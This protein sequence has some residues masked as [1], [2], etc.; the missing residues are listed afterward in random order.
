[1]R[2]S[3]RG[4]VASVVG[5]FGFAHQLL[6]SCKSLQKENMMRCNEIL[7]VFVS[8]SNWLTLLLEG[9]TRD[10]ISLV[11]RAKKTGKVN[12]SALRICSRIELKVLVCRK[13]SSRERRN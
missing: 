8:R 9:Q 7:I 5:D 12:C 11:L 6:I 1:M 13:I 10:G 2:A 4:K 3:E